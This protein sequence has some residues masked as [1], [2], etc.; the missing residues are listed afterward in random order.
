MNF[1]IT[2]ENVICYHFGHRYYGIHEIM[3]MYHENVIPINL[4]YKESIR[5]EE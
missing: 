4:N 1:M 2:T 5:S 3:I